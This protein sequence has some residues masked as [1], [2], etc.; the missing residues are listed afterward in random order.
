MFC[1][2]NNVLPF[3]HHLHHISKHCSMD[4]PSFVIKK[5]VPNPNKPK[6]KIF[7]TPTRPP[8][9]ETS[10]GPRVNKLNIQMLSRNIFEQVFRGLPVN[11]CNEAILEE[12]HKTLLKHNMVQRTDSYMK[13]VQ[14]KVPPLEGENI[15]E[16][17]YTIGEQQQRPYR[18]LV[19]NLLKEIPKAP[20]KWLMQQGWTRYVPGQEPERVPYPLEEGLV[21][22]I[23]VC[24]AVGKAPTLA[25]AVS[26]EAW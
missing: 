1:T 8:T 26:R 7:E 11:K 23:E 16:H 2:K 4:R 17:F 14:F 21:F 19:D 15:V 6:I 9:F 25:T 24:M 12:C 3:K 10:L 18:H 22:D 20:D 13:D 5:Y